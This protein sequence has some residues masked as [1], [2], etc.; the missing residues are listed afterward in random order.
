MRME[1]GCNNA[2]LCKST[3]LTSSGIAST[4]SKKPASIFR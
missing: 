4:E 3:L 2:F 1:V